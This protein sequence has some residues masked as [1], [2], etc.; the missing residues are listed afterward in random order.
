MESICA[1]T[2]LPVTAEKSLTGLSVT[3]IS[4]ARSITARASGCSEPCS[5]DAAICMNSGSPRV[6]AGTMSV[7]C[8][9]P[10]VNV[11][12]L[13]TITVLIFSACSSAAAFLTSTPACAPRPVPTMMAVGVASPNAHGQAMTSTAT[14][15]INAVTNSA[16]NHQ[17]IPNVT[18]LMATTTGTKIPD[19]VSAMR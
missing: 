12:V 2:P 7:T 13:S 8:G 16:V 5:S 6:S 19:M 15:W 17:V 14:A 10:S 11:P 4:S 18:I 1:L 9:L 3:F